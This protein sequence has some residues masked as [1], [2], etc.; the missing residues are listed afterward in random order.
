[1]AKQHEK[2]SPFHTPPFQS[3]LRSEQ[4]VAC[5]I[6]SCHLIPPELR[7]CSHHKLT[8]TDKQLF[9]SLHQLPMIYQDL[10]QPIVSHL[11]KNRHP[12]IK[13]L[14]LKQICFVLFAELL[15]SNSEFI[16]DVF[17]HNCEFVFQ[18]NPV[19]SVLSTCL[20]RVTPKVNQAIYKITQAQH[21]K[22]ISHT[23]TNFSQS[24]TPLSPH[25]PHIQVIVVQS[26]AVFS[27]SQSPVT[28]GFARHFT[29][30]H[31][32]S[33]FMGNRFPS[34]AVEVFIV[35]P[36]LKLGEIGPDSSHIISEQPPRQHFM[37]IS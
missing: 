16:R 2:S 25:N 15:C 18:Q 31:S 7:L 9:S 6:V 14:K 27:L 11:P 30:T 8:D 3:L 19:N 4:C 17:G 1:M 10:C 20:F 37:E 35:T 26:G 33:F 22:L 12:S 23:G 21:K 29:N 24:L 28:G 36:D 32:D 13:P 34:P 5:S